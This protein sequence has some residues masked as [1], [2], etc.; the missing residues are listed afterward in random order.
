MT[1]ECIATKLRNEL[2]EL[3]DEQI[4]DIDVSEME[5]TFDTG[6]ELSKAQHNVIQIA[7]EQGLT[8]LRKIKK[9]VE[10]T[11]SC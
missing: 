6:D 9:F 8:N 4:S 2:L 3:I 10:E 5:R 1:D 11:K 7:S